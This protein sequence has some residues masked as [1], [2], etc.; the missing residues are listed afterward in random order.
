MKVLREMLVTLAVAV[1][2]F[3]LL[4]FTIQSSVVVGSSMEPNLQNGQ[5]LVVN[6][7]AYAIGAPERGDVVV[8]RSPGNLST[9]FIKRI[10][11]LPGDTV[12]V[13]D[14][15]VI[16]NNTALNEPYIAS[17]PRYTLSR[18]T[19]PAGNYF[20]LGDNRN[21]SNDSHYGWFLPRQNIIGKA[22]ITT[23]PPRYW[24]VVRHYPLAQQLGQ[25]ASK[26]TIWLGSALA[27]LT[28]D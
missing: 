7:A 25:V 12:E 6:K 3:F 28:G 21:N 18:E 8:F 19:V 9:E 1:A 14:G 4:Q 22:W 17:P 5:Q 11:G 13:R 10:I 20:V 15:K 26:S 16:V 23:W 27:R 2:M 24:G